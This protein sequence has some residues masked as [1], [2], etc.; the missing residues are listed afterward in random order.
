MCL[1]KISLGKSQ[2]FLQVTSMSGL[3]AKHHE[4]SQL[5]SPMNKLCPKALGLWLKKLCYMALYFS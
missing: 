2:L 5:A 4:A 1:F 3:L